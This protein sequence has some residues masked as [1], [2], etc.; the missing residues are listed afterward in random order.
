M[1]KRAFIT[2]VAG[3]DGSYLAELLLSKNYD[4]YGLVRHSTTGHNLKNINNIV[5][6]IE[7][8]EGDI[9]DSS[10]IERNI[11]TIKPHEIYNL[12]AQSHVGMSFKLPVMT[13][14]V[15]GIAV[16]KMLEAIRQ[17]GF[18]SKFYQA[19][20]SELFGNTSDNILNENSHFD[21]VSPYGCAKLFA[22][23]IVKNYRDSYNM[24]ACS[25]IL[26]NHESPRR[27]P[28]F[29]TRKITKA[30][31]R[32][33]EG[34]QEKLGLGNLSS[35]RDWGHAKD[36]VEGMWLM[37]Q[38]N[39]PKD[40]ILATGETHSV[41]E[42]VEEVFNS[43][44]MNYK[45]FVYVDPKF[46]RPVDVNCLIGDSTRAKRDLGWEPKFKFSDLVNDMVQHDL[47]IEKGSVL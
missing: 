36:Y 33:K 15:T 47:N 44:G 32:I 29:V 41:R 26:F 24:F 2:G 12:A 16:L 31:V 40:Y 22:H 21:P 43:L 28:A 30:A 34:K 7:I 38:N 45:D 5:N 39:S 35:R 23:S 11:S 18:N 17:S 6:D 14:E 27:G 46:Y 25:G 19:S 1:K 20:T 4:V 3:Q 8:L 42:F 37:L 10:F 13:S 9:T